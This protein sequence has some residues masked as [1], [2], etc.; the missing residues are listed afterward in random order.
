MVTSLHDYESSSYC[1]TTSA[2][3]SC[4]TVAVRLANALT[5]AGDDDNLIAQFVSVEMSVTD[6]HGRRPFY[7]HWC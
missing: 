1:N 7:F 2:A 4:V 6:E 5:R 3:C